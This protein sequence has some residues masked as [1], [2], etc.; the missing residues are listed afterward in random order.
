MLQNTNLI[1]PVISSHK[2]GQAV[3]IP[4]LCSAHRI[5]L[6][7]AF[8]CA[9]PGAPVLLETTCNQVNQYGGYTG[10]TPERFV[11]F[12]G[13][14]A[15]EEGFSQERILLSG[16]HLGPLVW[17]GQPAGAAMEKAKTMVRDY[18]L[19]GYTKIHL[20]TSMPCADDANLSVET[21]ARR[22]AE[23]AAIAESA[24]RNRQALRYVI[25]TEVPA[26]GGASTEDEG[27]LRITTP[28]SAAQTI[29][30]SRQAFYQAGLEAAWD[31]VIAVVVQPGVEFGVQDVQPY[32]PAAARE[33]AQFIETIPVMVYEAHSTD[34]QTRFALHALVEDHFAILKVGPA[35]TFAFREAVFALA[36]MEA[37][38]FA[39]SE[40][41]QIREV[42]DEAM[43]ANPLHWQ[44]H[45]TGTEQELKFAR[46][47][48]LSD[49][50]RY[51]WPVPGVQAALNRLLE[52]LS[53]K[54]LPLSLISQAA[55]LAYQ[56]I[57]DGEAENSPR[58]I[59]NLNI[60]TV[61]ESYQAACGQI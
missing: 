32:R 10:M 18:V 7:A 27:Q 26:A 34:H 48:S 22:S 49:R 24:A 52:N 16:D 13:E 40:Q 15:R 20:D 38:L 30:V 6:Q 4:A 56:K 37:E 14:L 23:L 41:S 29:E 9:P 11:N 53:K 5:V 42:L 54:P 28:E 8:R 35:L 39:R 45:Y 33:L 43:L 44:K 25:G 46:Q 55:P 1:D 2:K 59:L 21:I 51:Y 12:I 61:L 3:G 60:Q 17:V 31:R 36:F 58:S 47:Y 57:R 19:A 50:I